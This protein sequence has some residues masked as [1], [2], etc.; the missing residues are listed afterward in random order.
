MC[1]GG[2]GVLSVP[3]HFVTDISQQCDLQEFT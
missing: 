3:E 1:G 2:G